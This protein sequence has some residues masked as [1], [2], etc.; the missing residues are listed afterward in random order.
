MYP[1]SRSTK[2]FSPAAVATTTAPPFVSDANVA[3]YDSDGSAFIATSVFPA[4][5]RFVVD[6]KS[7][8]RYDHKGIRVI[9]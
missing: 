2:P 7:R 9:L 5:L 4:D 8:Y 6:V 1:P 3:Q